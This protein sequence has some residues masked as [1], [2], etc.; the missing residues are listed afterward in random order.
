MNM[1]M[2]QKATE[3]VCVDAVKKFYICIYAG[4]DKLSEINFLTKNGPN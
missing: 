4:R 1:V 3:N 2:R